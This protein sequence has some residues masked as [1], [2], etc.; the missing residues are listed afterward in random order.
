M[1]TRFAAYYLARPFQRVSGDATKGLVK[2]N[3][4]SDT[5]I[6][7][8]GEKHANA[9]V[10]V[11]S[12]DDGNLLDALAV[13]APGA[14]AGLTEIT[15]NY[16]L[17]QLALMHGKRT[18]E[19]VQEFLQS[20]VK[21]GTDVKVDERLRVIRALMTEYTNKGNIENDAVVQDL[22]GMLANKY[23]IQADVKL[24]S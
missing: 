8:L 5:G 9:G 20:Y 22:V 14:V 13:I 15:Q 3:L 19:E 16:A 2:K 12:K 18:P 10:A 4:V 24:V 23:K 6:R 1:L 7:I 17:M 21:D 11:L